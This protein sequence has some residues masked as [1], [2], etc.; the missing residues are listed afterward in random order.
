M[1][2]PFCILLLG[3]LALGGGIPAW[4]QDSLEGGG[5]AGDTLVED[6]VDDTVEVVEEVVVAL[7]RVAMTVAVEGDKGRIT[8]LG[9][10]VIELFPDDAPLHVA[11]FLE[12]VE[13][14]TYEGVAFHRIVPGFIIQGGDPAS[15]AD[16]KS[17]RLGLGSAG[18][19]LP[20]E[21]GRQHTRGAVAAA[22][23]PDEANP[24]Q[25]T[26]CYQF[27]ICLADLP[28]LDR[29]NHSVFGQ[30]VEGIEVVEKV[31]RVKNAG[32]ANMNRALQRVYMTE[33]Q[34]VP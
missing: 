31:A 21:V 26:S 3:G 30:V 20:P 24:D 33:I 4:A 25:E 32:S 13:A 27:Y 34:V 1:R 10:M 17:P 6:V 28:G 7:P 18:C 5:G 12:Q 11:N 16:W 14:G 22:R 2:T 29:G 8:R 9:R 15:R 23:R 19:S